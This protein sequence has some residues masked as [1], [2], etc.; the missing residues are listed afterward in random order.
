M[1][2]LAISLT[3]ALFTSIVEAEVF[4]VVYDQGGVVVTSRVELVGA[5]LHNETHAVVEGPKEHRGCIEASRERSIEVTEKSRSHFKAVIIDDSII[6]MGSINP[7][8]IVTLRYVPADYMIRFVSEAL[9][10]EVLEKFMPGY[11]EWLK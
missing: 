1:S 5:K 2:A 9:V 4:I 7:L 3:L 10:D 8:Q 6:Y 11:Q